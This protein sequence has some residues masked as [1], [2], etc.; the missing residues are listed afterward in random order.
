LG[1]GN[2]I[3]SDDAV[4]PKLVWE[5][6]KRRDEGRKH[7]GRGTKTRKHE[8]QSDVD[9]GSLI[10]DRNM[11]CPIHDSRST[12]HDFKTA[13]LGGLELMEMIQGYD[14]VVI[15]DAIKTPH[16]V[17]GTVYELKPEDFKN[18]LHINNLHDTSFLQA[19]ELGKRLGLNLP[20]QI[21]IIAVE[22]VEDLLFSNDFSP[23]VQQKWPEIVTEVEGLVSEK[24]LMI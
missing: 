11:Q 24:I 13:A 4:G 10:V 5:L 15:I 19:L 8:A 22:I 1:L 12:I 7:E 3:L 14:Q 16:G 18:A 20:K 23:K 21:D 6:E 17:P 2:D 9:R